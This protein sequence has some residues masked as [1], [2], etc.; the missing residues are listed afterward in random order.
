MNIFEFDD[1]KEVFREK[2]KTM[3][4]RGHGQL[5][6]IAKLLG[7]HTTLLTHIFK[8]KSNLH[9]EQALQICG[10]LGFTTL[11]T[12]YFM[13]LVQI[14][15]A[16]D[17]PCK[18]YYRAQQETLRKR[19]LDLKARFEP[20]KILDEKDQAQFYSEWTYS[21]VNLLTAIEGFQTPYAIAERLGLRVQEVTRILDFL[22]ML[23]LC[24]RE[25]SDFRIGDAQTFLGRD[26]A[27]LR[28]HL[29]NWRARVSEK[30]YDTNDDDIMYSQPVVVSKKDFAV[31]HS[32]ILKFLQ[33]FRE[34]AEPSAC[35]ELCC[36]NLDWVRVR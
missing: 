26:S 35:E 21:A 5:L 8:G 32:K 10:H 33:D 36:L 24:V 16:G 9:P 11:E 28:R 12:D 7:V 27:L 23:G 18:D 30:I 29:L 14:A 25:G 34:T 2:L 3:P 22:T 13:V 31:I 4:K 19:S 15:R 1:Y 6:R 20:K 17:K